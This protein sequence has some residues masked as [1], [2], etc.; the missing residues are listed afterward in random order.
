VTDRSS[1]ASVKFKAASQVGSADKIIARSRLAL[2]PELV[3]HIHRVVSDPGPRVGTV[4]LDD[5]DYDSLIDGLLAPAHPADDIWLFAYGSLIWKPACEIA[6]QRP[7]LLRGWH[8]S[9]CM[10]LTRF[11]GTPEYPG[12][13]LALDRGGACRGVGQRLPAARAPELLGQLLRR[14]MSVKPPTNCPRWVIANVDGQRRP[15]IAFTIDRAAAN[16][17]GGLSVVATAAILARAVGHWG[18]GA[19]YLLNTVQHLEA[20]GIRDRYLWQLQELVAETIMSASGLVSRA[21][22]VGRCVTV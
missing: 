9:F 19:E 8:R 20:L 6:E 11:R 14:E 15:M 1:E 18:T 17:V 16:Y 4:P 2:T 12:L 10:R 21:P 22:S 13:M 7:A 5:A 3:A